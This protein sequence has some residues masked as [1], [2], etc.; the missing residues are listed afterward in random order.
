MGTRELELMYYYG[1]MNV[2]IYHYGN[3]NKVMGMRENAWDRKVIPAALL[4][5]HTLS[6]TNTYMH[7]YTH[8][9]THTHAH[10]HAHAHLIL[11]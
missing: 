3:G 10:I 9:H 7:A 5:T 8:T 6:Q 1:N 4:Y 2:F 11:Y